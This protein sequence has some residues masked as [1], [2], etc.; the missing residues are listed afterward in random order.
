MELFTLKAIQVITPDK[1]KIDKTKLSLYFDKFQYKLS[2]CMLNIHYFR[3]IKNSSEYYDRLVSLKEYMSERKDGG[4]FF[5]PSPIR[6]FADIVDNL[7]SI[8]AYSLWRETIGTTDLMIRIQYDKLD[9][10]S[11]KM[12]V[13]QSLLDELDLVNDFIDAKFLK[14]KPM[15]N[16]EK[17]VVYQVN[18]KHKFRI[19]LSSECRTI[20][21]VKKLKETL[22]RH[23][24]CISKALLKWIDSS[25]KP[26]KNP[27]A[28][29]PGI[30]SWSHYSF[31]FDDESLITLLCL[32]HQEWIGKVCR[33]EKKINT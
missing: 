8:E 29:S 5:R 12:S 10:Y 22:L 24:V 1:F 15:K 13:F 14:S 19:Y 18:P 31:D 17:E 11:N 2:I 4:Y 3:Y 7:P 27:F 16:F 33:I 32:Q 28:L 9:I 30:W 20:E 21:Q 23:D 6:T 25:D 26:P